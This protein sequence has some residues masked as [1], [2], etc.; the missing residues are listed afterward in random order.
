MHIHARA[1]ARYCARQAL[2]IDVEERG[3]RAIAAPPTP[4]RP[5]S[6]APR[7]RRAPAPRACRAAALIARRAGGAL[8]LLFL[9]GMAVAG[10]YAFL[11][12][13][14]AHFRRGAWHAR[15][16]RR[17]GGP[18]P[19]AARHA[20]SAPCSD[21][22]RFHSCM[23]SRLASRVRGRTV[24]EAFRVAPVEARFGSS[25][26]VAGR[27]LR[28][29]RRNTA[30]ALRPRHRAM[31]RGATPRWSR[32]LPSQHRVP[33][34]A[35]FAGAVHEQ[36]GRARGAWRRRC[37]RGGRRHPLWSARSAARRAR[38]ALHR[39]FARWCSCRSAAFPW[40]LEPFLAKLARD[41][42][43]R[44]AI[45]RRRR[46]RRRSGRASARPSTRHAARR[47]PTGAGAREAA[48]A[49]PDPGTRGPSPV[50]A[51]M[52]VEACCVCKVHRS[53][54]RSKMIIGGTTHSDCF[55]PCFWQCAGQ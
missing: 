48:G 1:R 5:R 12:S 29:P 27:A 36:R 42:V 55:E 9:L 17:R 25:L 26:V 52:H 14:R 43:A 53:L 19:G 46:E 7:G 2:A 39:R 11:H 40:M 16:Q 34:S 15:C 45:E 54:A 41:A 38:R 35:Y 23:R 30:A 13:S 8:L 4:A 21:R 51:C 24:G 49:R 22:R 6:R 32:A 31:G 18:G 10:S 3:R 44:G 20:R 37:A 28:R 47:A 33:P 50:V